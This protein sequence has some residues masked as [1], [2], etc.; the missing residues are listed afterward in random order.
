[1]STCYCTF[2][3]IIVLCC[4]LL[5]FVV[6]CCT[7]LFIIVLETLSRECKSILPSEMLYAD[8]LVITAERLEEFR[9]RY[10]AWK[11]CMES[12]KLRV[13][14]AQTRVMISD[15]N[16]GQYLPLANTDAEFIVIM[17]VLTPSF[18]MIVLTGCIS[19]IVD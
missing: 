8:D 4:F 11:S 10:A 12:K 2:L 19:D 1:M 3:F 15:M 6:Y 17:L 9:V 7:L 16:Q 18:A 13:N 5:L 14:L